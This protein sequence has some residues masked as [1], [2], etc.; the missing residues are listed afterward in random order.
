MVLVLEGNHQEVQGV[1]DNQLMVE[2][3]VDNLVQDPVER[4][5]CTHQ[6]DPEVEDLEVEDLSCLVQDG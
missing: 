1:H 3:L 2:R 6:E 5:V 4:L